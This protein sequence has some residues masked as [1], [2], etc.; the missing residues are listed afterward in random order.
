ML[1]G[2]QIT[3][4]AGSYA[5]ALLGELVRLRRPGWLSTAVV[6]AAVG[7]GFAAHSA[8]LYHHAV[9]AIGAPLSSDRDWFLLAAWLLVLAYAYLT[10]YRPRV[11]FGVFLLPLALALIAAGALGAS[12]EPYTRE[13]AGRI[14]GMIHGTSLV[15]SIFAVTLGFAAGLMYLGQARRLK[16]KGAPREVVRLPSLE[17]LE[18]ANGHSI[19]LA[20]VMMLVGVVSGGV[21]SRAAA[22][23]ATGGLPWHDPL[24][25]STLVMLAWLV[26]AVVL[27]SLWRRAARGRRV[28]LL[29]LA[30]FL[31]LAV[32]LGTAL[33][34]GSRHGLPRQGGAIGPSPPSAPTNPP[35]SA[36]VGPK[37]ATAPAAPLP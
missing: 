24:V 33:L 23:G 10:W 18:R 13:S 9:H 25:L 20:A 32:S 34:F 17:W 35:A 29:T 1:S 16:R 14:W 12:P 22:V 5:V 26:L 28:A 4:F 27:G 31:F 15:A 3:C 6:I 11:A 36:E 8:F 7:A 37:R 2:V 19:V 21:L 30:S